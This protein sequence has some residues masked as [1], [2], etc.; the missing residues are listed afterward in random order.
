MAGARLG[1]KH[2]WL[3]SLVQFKNTFRY[4]GPCLAWDN[5]C[6][7]VRLFAIKQITRANKCLSSGANNRTFTFIE[8]NTWIVRE[9]S[10][11]WM[12]H[13][14]IDKVKAV[15][16]FLIKTNSCSNGNVTFEISVYDHHNCYFRKNQTSEP[17][18]C[19]ITGYV[20]TVSEAGDPNQTKK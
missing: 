11:S 9:M 10:I 18:S 14:S 4:F 17:S 20:R 13:G 8:L 6:P 15:S 1:R 3:V 7:K 5:P 12:Y 16:K 2:S 19:K